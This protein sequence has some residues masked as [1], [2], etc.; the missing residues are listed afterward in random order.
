M[1]RTDTIVPPSL[2]PEQPANPRPV[3]GIDDWPLHLLITLDAASP[4][5]LA[6]VMSSGDLRRQTIFAALSQG[7][8]DAPQGFL[9]GVAD[10]NI[11]SAS[12]GIDPLT[13]VAAVLAHARARVI[14]A[15]AF[16]VCPPRL[17][18]FLLR[19]GPQPFIVAAYKRL[20]DLAANRDAESS[21][22]YLLS[23]DQVQILDIEKAERLRP[24]VLASKL[25]RTIHASVEIDRVNTVIE[26]GLR[27][28]S[29]VTPDWLA[30][31]L[32]GATHKTVLGDWL[33][34]LAERFDALLVEPPFFGDDETVLLS[35][36]A[37]IL[38]AGRRYKNCL[39][40]M[41]SETLAGK[42]YFYEIKCDK[43]I[44]HTKMLT[45]G[46][47]YLDGL[48]GIGNKQ[49]G[50]VIAKRIRDEFAHVGLPSLFQADRPDLKAI[51]SLHAPW[52][53]RD[54]DDEDGE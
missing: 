13:K 17:L 38:D 7:V 32:A 15:A 21:A 16:G 49:V 30:Q 3:R 46:T 44:A 14:V 11:R 10:Q 31:S 33:F 35:S 22:R 34:G 53:F 27:A 9:D 39:K 23:R 40:S 18:A 52:T 36:G 20:Y 37:M 28:C 12:D 48:Y 26:V 51:A 54:L 6:R 29:S 41:I 8:V 47:G 43:V 5:F 50:K 19:L 42:S 2:R 45:D 4:G 25:A 1:H 24:E